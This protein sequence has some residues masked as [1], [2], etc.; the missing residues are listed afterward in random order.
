M[1]RSAIVQE[2]AL[3]SFGILFVL[4]LIKHL[5]GVPVVA[6]FG[7]TAALGLQL[8]FP[9]LRRG[10]NGVTTASIGLGLATWRI[11]LKWFLMWGLLVTPFFVFGH[12]FYQTI[13][14]GRGFNFALP[15]DILQRLFMQTLVVALAE[16]VFF[17]G[18]L[19]E[20]FE[21]LWPARR[22]LFG[23]PFGAAILLGSAVFALAHFVGEY[24]PARLGPFFPSLLFGLLRARSGSIWGA[25]GLHAYFNVLGDLVWA[26]YR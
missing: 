18:Y 10:R 15:E 22:K 25:A 2:A 19:Q 21:R 13:F 16:E 6:S 20:R 4:G 23:V 12:H 14:M 3:A 8:Y 7:F 1:P 11:D 26:S 24:N 17:R 9:L 5:K